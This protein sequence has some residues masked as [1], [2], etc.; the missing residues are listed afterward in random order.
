MKDLFDECIHVLS[1]IDFLPRSNDAQDVL[2]A[3]TALRGV[4]EQ[5]WRILVDVI[6]AVCQ[7][8]SFK[9]GQF[10]QKLV[11]SNAVYEI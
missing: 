8:I 6:L 5:L 10:K 11:G 9:S 4:K 2:S 3:V 7:C 1:T